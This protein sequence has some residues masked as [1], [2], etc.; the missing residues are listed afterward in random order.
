VETMVPFSGV[1]PDHI[2]EKLFATIREPM[3][4]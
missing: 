3:A 4:K 2:V 1:K